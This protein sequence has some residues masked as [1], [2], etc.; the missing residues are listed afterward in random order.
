[1]AGVGGGALA[2]ISKI[3]RV[4]GRTV[5][6]VQEV[7]FERSTPCEAA[8]NAGVHL[9]QHLDVR[10]IL[11]GASSRGGC[12]QHRGVRQHVG[13]G[14]EVLDRVL[15]GRFIVVQPRT[16]APGVGL[17]A[18]TLVAK[19]HFQWV[20]SGLVEHFDVCN[21][22]RVHLNLVAGAVRTTVRAGGIQL[23]GVHAAGIRVRVK[24]VTRLGARRSRASIA[25]IPREGAVGVG[26]LVHQRQGKWGTCR[27]RSHEVSCHLGEHG[28]VHRGVGLA[29]KSSGGGLDYLHDHRLEVII[30]KHVRAA[31]TAAGSR[32]IAP[33]QRDFVGVHAAIQKRN[34]CACTG[35]HVG[36]RE[37]GHRGVVHGG[38]HGGLGVAAEGRGDAQAQGQFLVLSFKSDK[39]A[40]KIHALK[41]V[42]VRQGPGNVVVA[43]TGIAFGRQVGLPRGTSFQRPNGVGDHFGVHFHGEGVGVGAAAFG[44]H[45]QRHGA[46]DQVKAFQLKRVFVR[47]AVQS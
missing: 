2:S 43:R 6:E 14:V 8:F 19:R 13:R 20:A 3:P 47:G 39:R 38:S 15:Q 22:R 42:S 46:G 26:A 1:M 11:A 23:N 12:S 25:E 10:H 40:L 36:Q 27:R 34:F 30:V 35:R 16:V 45:G 24:E 17:T 33:V 41:R 28:V 21:G 18:H 31:R 32:T 7:H 29:S 37:V 9:R 4:A 44:L 5:A